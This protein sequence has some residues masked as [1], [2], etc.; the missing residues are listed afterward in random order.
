[1]QQH[2]PAEAEPD[3]CMLLFRA[4]LS[5]RSGQLFPK[6]PS[7]AGLSRHSARPWWC[8]AAESRARKAVCPLL[9]LK[10][11][12]C[13]LGWWASNRLSFQQQSVSGSTVWLVC[14]AVGGSWHKRVHTRRVYSESG[15]PAAFRCD[16]VSRRLP[17]S[18]LQVAQN[19]L[20]SK[21]FPLQLAFF[22]CWL[23]GYLTKGQ[24]SVKVK[25]E[26]PTQAGEQ[27][28]AW[29]VMLSALISILAKKPLLLL[30]AF[31]IKSCRTCIFLTLSLQCGCTSSVLHTRWCTTINMLHSTSSTASEKAGWA[32][33][34]S[35]C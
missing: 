8:R 3:L 14:I 5:I 29:C 35:R 1:M 26:L 32:P 33:G 4:Q 16:S 9:S 20:E 18:F 12:V 27:A 30:K 25:P 10:D 17:C 22:Q 31:F 15:D 24:H 34:W 28:G 19:R 23:S 11:G 21:Y 6:V 13:L 7:G 2:Y